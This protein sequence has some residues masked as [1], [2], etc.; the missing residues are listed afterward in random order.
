MPKTCRRGEI[1]RKAFTRKA[2]TTKAGTRVKATRIPA[3]CVPDKGAPGKGP[4]TLPTPQP[5][6]LSP[7]KE[8]LPAKERCDI[9]FRRARREGFA[10]VIRKVTL[11]R[12]ITA[13]QS[14]RT[15]IRKDANCLR[16]R[17]GRK[18]I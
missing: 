8:T 14:T 1:L 5:G 15:K 17:L 10:T 7:W 9:L 12:N 6:G 11:L 4:K 18:P 3:T 16:K 13:D 2:F